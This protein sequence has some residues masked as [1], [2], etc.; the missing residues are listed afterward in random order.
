MAINRVQIRPTRRRNGCHVATVV[1]KRQM[2]RRVARGRCSGFVTISSCRHVGLFSGVFNRISVGSHADLKAGVKTTLLTKLNI[3]TRINDRLREPRNTPMI[4]ISRRRN[5]TPTPPHPCFGPKMSAPVSITTEGFRTTVGRRMLRPRVKGKLWQG[6]LV[7]GGRLA[8][9]SFLRHLGVRR[10]LISTNCRLGGQ[11]NLHCPSCMGISDR[12][13]QIEN[14]GFVIANGNGYYFRP[15]RRGGCGI[16]N[17]VGRRPALFSSCGPKVSL[18]ELIGI[19]YGELLGGPVS[20]HRD[21]ITRPGQSTGPFGLSSCSVLHF[22]PERGSAR[23]GR[24]PCFGRENVGVKARFTFRGRF[25]LTAGRQ[26]SKLDFTGVTFPLSLPSGP[27]DVIKLRRQN[28]PEQ[29]SNGTCG[30]GTRKDGDDSKL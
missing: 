5:T 9:G 24:C 10:L 2:D 27:S 4:V 20:I 26:G 3:T 29:R 19:M 7:T 22:G 14:S 21:E 11:S 16:V 17:F 30:N 12:K 15:P 25:F 6:A 1:G 8:C 18:S 28:E 23:Q 13:R